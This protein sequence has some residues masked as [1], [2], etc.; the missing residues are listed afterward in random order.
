M[1]RVYK[2]TAHLPATVELTPRNT[3]DTITVDIEGGKNPGKLVI[4][5][6]TVE[7]RPKGRKVNVYRGDWDLFATACEKGLDKVHSPKK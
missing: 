7:W 3:K 1:P 6:G 4:A 2:I 5:Q